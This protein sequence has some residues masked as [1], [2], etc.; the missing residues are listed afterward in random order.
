MTSI[1]A[2]SKIF[3]LIIFT[4]YSS[5]L[6]KQPGNLAS[7]IIISYA[8][9]II[10]MALSVSSSIAEKSFKNNI[11]QLVIQCTWMVKQLG[12]SAGCIQGRLS[13]DIAIASWLLNEKS[14]Y[15]SSC[16][17]EKLF[18]LISSFKQRDFMVRQPGNLAGCITG[19]LR[20]TSCA[21]RYPVM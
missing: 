18:D 11:M 14:L 12:N 7:C 20:Y 10:W 13:Q 17:A 9:L 8:L 19:C 6:V 2:N 4:L 16:I 3:T 5:Y 1:V 21:S 15:K